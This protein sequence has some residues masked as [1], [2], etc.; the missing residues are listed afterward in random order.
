ML[1]YGLNSAPYKG[2]TEHAAGVLECVLIV[3]L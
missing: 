3:H 1:V 2:G